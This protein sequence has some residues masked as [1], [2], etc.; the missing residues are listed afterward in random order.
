VYQLRNG[1]GVGVEAPQYG[2][3]RGIYG[4]ISIEFGPQPASKDVTPPVPDAK[5]HKG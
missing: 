1:S 2:Q 4:G 3:R 5:D